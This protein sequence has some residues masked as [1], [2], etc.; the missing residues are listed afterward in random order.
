MFRPVL[1]SAWGKLAAVALL[2]VG[3]AVGLLLTANLGGFRLAATGA[4]GSAGTATAPSYRPPLALDFPLSVLQPG[5]EPEEAGTTELRVE[6]VGAL[7]VSYEVP[8]VTAAPPPPPAP[9]CVADL[10]ST[11]TGLA[12][13]VSTLTSAD[14]A[15]GVLEQVN[16]LGTAANACAQQVAGV[17]STGIETLTHV[18][19]QL[20]GIVATVQALPLL[21][22]AP[23][24]EAGQAP[25]GGIK[26]P[27]EAT[28][29]V[30][31]DGLGMTLGA[32]NVVTGSVGDVLRLVLNPTQQ[33]R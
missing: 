9:P 20:N 13:A 26:N 5:P 19:H 27:V 29:G 15:G 17:G 33:E 1:S 11:V 28:L 32:M 23:S 12:A 21:S 22:P 7:E 8:V 3:M 24:P 4:V 25:A 31:G 6:Q 18:G 16:S 14:Q 30:V 2:V 10:S